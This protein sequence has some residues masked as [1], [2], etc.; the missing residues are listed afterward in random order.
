MPT[1]DSFFCGRPIR[2]IPFFWDIM[3]KLF[4]IQHKMVGFYNRDGVCLLRGTE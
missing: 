3:L 2:S 1:G 4:P